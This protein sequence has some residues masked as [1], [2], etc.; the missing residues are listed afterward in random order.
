LNESVLSAEVF[1][2]PQPGGG[3][4]GGDPWI[5][6]FH[7]DNAGADTGEM[8]EI[9]GPAGLSLSGWSVVGYNGNGGSSYATFPMS[10]TLLDQ[11]AGFGTAQFL[12][13]QI[14]NGSPDGLAL[15]DPQGAVIEFIS[16]EGVM[17][18]SGG[19]ADGMTST[20]VGV[21]EISST[22]V[23]FS[24]QLTGT[25]SEQADF[26]WMSPGA[27]TGGVPNN[28]QTF[29]A[30]GVTDDCNENGIEDATDISMG[31]SLDVDTD[32]VPD[33][34]QT[35]WTDLGFALA[36]VSGNP[37][38][39]GLGVFASDTTYTIT[40]ANGAPSALTVLFLALTATPVPFKGGFLVPIPLLQSVT[41]GTN[42]S[43]G[44]KLVGVLPPGLPAGIDIVLQFWIADAAAIV[45]A[46]ASN[47]L[48]GTTTN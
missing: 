38:L 8:I 31:T 47:G 11:E 45:G 36:G 18:A 48:M 20:D 7:Y 3:N 22:P 24:L 9:A 42:A 29:V 30:V 6:E 4:P 21:S 1:A 14:Q 34:C 25:G 10:G 33:E 23:G 19:P 32:G 39:D 17:L 37:T 12:T 5:N 41:L 13:G 43:G 28:G 26:T 2:T 40:L 16:Y 44:L 46:S 35:P 27:E 15:I